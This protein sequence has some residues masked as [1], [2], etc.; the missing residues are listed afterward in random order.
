MA[1]IGTPEKIMIAA[2]SYGDTKK[3]EKSE[4]ISN[5]DRRDT[6]G[7]ALARLLASYI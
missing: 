4:F 6:A 3:N 1:P 7:S 5:E 2:G